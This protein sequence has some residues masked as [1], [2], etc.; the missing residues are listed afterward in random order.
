[1]LASFPPFFN[2]DPMKTYAKIME[3]NIH[4]PSHFSTDAVSLISK[5]LQ[6]RVSKRL[7]MLAGGANDIK[8]HPWFKRINFDA[9]ANRT[10]KAPIVPRIKNDLD[11]S[12]FD[13]TYAG[14]SQKILPYIDDGS[15]W[16]AEF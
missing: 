14:D 9:I 15:R 6:P 12:N 11:T 10:I 4:Y 16:D 13:I 7:G 2:E 5:L 1:M 8:Q 3:G